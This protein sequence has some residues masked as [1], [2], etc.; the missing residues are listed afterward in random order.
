MTPLELRIFEVYPLICPNCSLGMP[1]VAADICVRAIQVKMAP[2]LVLRIADIRPF[3]GIPRLE[4]RVIHHF[5]RSRMEPD[6]VYLRHGVQ[7]ALSIGQG[8]QRGGE[9]FTVPAVDGLWPRGQRTNL[10]A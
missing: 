10:R 3:P 6:K 9:C 8:G 2:P 1:G 7:I 5:S 4:G